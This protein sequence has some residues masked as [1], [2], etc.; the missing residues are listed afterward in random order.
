VSEAFYEAIDGTWAPAAIQRDG[1][2]VFR[3]GQGGGSRVSATTTEVPGSLPDL[4]LAEARSNLFMIRPGEDALDAALAAKGYSVKDPVNLYACAAEQLCDMPVPRV[5]MLPVWEPLEIMKDI[6][7][8]GGIG[9]ERLAVMHRV[10][11]PKTGFLGRHKDK[12]AGAAF[13][14]SYKG[15]TMVHAIEILPHQRRNGMG[16][17]V[18]RASAFWARKHGAKT[19]AV[20]CTQANEG[21]N[22]L[23]A[24]LGMPVVGQYHYRVRG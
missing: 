24:S 9:P 3:D 11:G 5:T 17:W 4:D 8:A 10:P 15:I 20:L 22:A 14:A 1:G 2:W 16:A 7:A 21:A 23:Y 12:P 6:W 19:V 18:M 13:T